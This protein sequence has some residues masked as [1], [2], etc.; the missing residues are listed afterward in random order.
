MVK[1]SR[2]GH[3]IIHA[4]IDKSF[5]QASGKIYLA[6]Y[7]TLPLDMMQHHV[8]HVTLRCMYEVV[9]RL[10][11]RDIPGARA[12]TRACVPRA[13]D[14]KHDQHN[15]SYSVSVTTCPV[16]TH[17]S[18]YKLTNPSSIPLYQTNSSNSANTLW[19]SEKM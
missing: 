12:S 11:P 4:L 17:E 18:T 16:Y 13:Y 9:P 6:D 19:Y 10:S 2:T 7:T 5:S 8:C 3:N 15:R 14:L 1:K